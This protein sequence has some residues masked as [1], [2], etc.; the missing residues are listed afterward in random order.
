M[1]VFRAVPP[2]A[3]E[4]EVLKQIGA[5]LQELS[6]L[7]RGL[8]SMTGG[9]RGPESA[10][11]ILESLKKVNATLAEADRNKSL[12]PAGFTTVGR[13]FEK[14]GATLRALGTDTTKSSR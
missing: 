14:I 13:E 6:K 5:E 7:L 4:I 9:T 8:P 3:R 10:A 1:L 2:S 12:T 11:S